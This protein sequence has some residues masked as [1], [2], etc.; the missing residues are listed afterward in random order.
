[1]RYLQTC[2]LASVLLGCAARE[3][4]PKSADGNVVAT[5]PLEPVTTPPPEH[6]SGSGGSPAVSSATL[7]LTYH[8]L[9]TGELFTYFRVRLTARMV[10]SGGGWRLTLQGNNADD[11]FLIYV[12]LDQTERVHAA[13]LVMPRSWIG[14]DKGVNPM[15]MDLAAHYVLIFA[16]PTDHPTAT[17]FAKAIMAQKPDRRVLG[18]DKPEPAAQN[19]S[20]FLQAYQ[21]LRRGAETRLAGVQMVA[22]NTTD[23]SGG[24]LHIR[25]EAASGP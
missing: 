3:T 23:P 16:S 1:M 15:S 9:E 24:A 21:G 8:D 14:D 10:A 18:Q 25:I 7:P 22:E 17:L 5:S 4:P 12:E 11:Q 13:E 2:V 20:A 6:G 19:V